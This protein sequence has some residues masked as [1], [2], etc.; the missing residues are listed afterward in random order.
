[1]KK[2]SFYLSR[3]S[4]SSFAGFICLFVSLFIWIFPVFA[5]SCDPSCA[6]A[7]ECRD[8]IAKCQ[9][10]WNQ[11]ETAKKPHVDAL[12]KME[13]DIAAFQARIKIIEADTI[14]KAQSIADGEKALSGFLGL[15][16]GRIR[17]MYIRSRAFNPLIEIFTSDTLGNAI[18]R[19]GYSQSVIDEDK[20]MIAKTAVSVKDLEEKKKTLEEEKGS[21]AYLK[22][23]TDKRAVSIRKLVGDANA[24]QGKLTSIL[25]SLSAQQQ[26]FLAAK[27]SNLNISRSAV[28]IGACIDDRNVDPGFSPRFALFT[29]GVPNRI[30]LNQYGAKGRAEAGQ[31]ARDILSAYYSADYTTGYN[32]GINIHVSGNNEYG[33]SFNENWNIEEYL[34]HLYEM[35]SNWPTEALR[36]QVIAARSYALSYTNN[37]SGSICPSQQ[38]QV[39]KKE[40]NSESWQ[41]AVRDTSGVVLTRGGTPIKAWFSSTHGGYSFTSGDIG[42]NSTDWTKR[43]VDATG[44]ISSFSDLFNTAYDRSSPWFYCDWG[45]RAQYN[46]TAWLKPEELADIVNILLLAKRDSSTQ[47]HLVQVDK[48]NPDGAETWDAG[49]V[50][51]ELA[52]R[53]GTPYTTVS[54]VSIGWDQVTGRTTQVTVSGNAGSNSFDGNEFKTYFNLRAPA[55][56]QIVGPLY[57]VEKR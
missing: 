10:A 14:R 5:Q 40:L 27:L 25:A 53:G 52:S 37:G 45:S 12:R 44:G 30:G 20:K 2:V 18:R 9:E 32:S 1:M 11:M 34:K 23:E 33:Q 24:Y 43:L 6:N 47:N 13:N 38:C 46:K 36:A 22:E 56:I 57:N 29:F 4:G 51:S 50:R 41:Q 55:T 42:W 39:V 35:P 16:G 17:N 21:L 19:L 26:Q 49:R 48:P 15:A 28:S 31:N 8:K 54:D 3:V 7:I